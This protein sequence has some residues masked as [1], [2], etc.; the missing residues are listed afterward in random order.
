MVPNTPSCPA[1][2]QLTKPPPP[3][4]PIPPKN[5]Q[6]RTA[7]Q[8]HQQRT[9]KTIQY[10]TMR[11]NPIR[12]RHPPIPS[13]SPDSPPMVP[14]RRAGL[15]PGP[16]WH[17]TMRDRRRSDSQ[18]GFSFPPIPPFSPFSVDTASCCRCWREWIHTFLSIPLLNR[19]YVSIEMVVVVREDELEKEFVF[20]LPLAGGS[21]RLVGRV[22]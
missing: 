4:P 10:N 6:H 12:F 9:H 2:F 19:A 1:S 20:P 7:T 16:G 14:N 11:R 22:L 3:P 8:T 13:C 21:A 17:A 18:P 15:R 5:Y